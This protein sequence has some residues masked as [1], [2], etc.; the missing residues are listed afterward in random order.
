[1]S[2]C[3]ITGSGFISLKKLFNKDYS[4]KACD[5]NFSLSKLSELIIKGGWPA[6]IECDEKISTNKI[7]GYISQ[8][9]NT[10]ASKIDSIKRDTIKMYSL[11][12]SL[13]RTLCRLP[14][15]STII[16]D[17]A[18]NSNITISNITINDYLESLRKLFII[19][20]IPA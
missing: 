1:M 10:D 5:G 15:I 4:F 18:E 2:L 9:I 6:N 16:T 7:K 3:E 19:E 13:S 20:E 12:H 14:K 11:F 17:L 8:I